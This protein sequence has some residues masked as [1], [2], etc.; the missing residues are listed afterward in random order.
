M[1]R[2]TRENGQDGTQ[3]GN[4]TF[5]Y[6]QDNHVSHDASVAQAPLQASTMN[7]VSKHVKLS[8]A[9]RFAKRSAIVCGQRTRIIRESCVS[10]A[11]CW[12][13]FVWNGPCAR[14]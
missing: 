4:H 2:V 13:S 6:A 3:L 8:S 9:G 5:G 11:H 12:K 7:R 10:D 14:S 1:D